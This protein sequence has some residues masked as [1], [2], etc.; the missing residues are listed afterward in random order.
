M[1]YISTLNLLWRGATPTL[2]FFLLQIPSD[3]TKKGIVF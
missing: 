1:S 2:K 3:G